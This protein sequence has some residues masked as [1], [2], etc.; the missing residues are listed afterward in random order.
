MLY[1]NGGDKGTCVGSLEGEAS[2]IQPEMVD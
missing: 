1:F 2:L